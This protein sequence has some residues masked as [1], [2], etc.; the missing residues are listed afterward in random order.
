M[1]SLMINRIWY[2]PKR[3]A[4]TGWHPEQRPTIEA[5][6]RSECQAMLA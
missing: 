6:R 4:G 2:Y 1:R 5:G 3:H